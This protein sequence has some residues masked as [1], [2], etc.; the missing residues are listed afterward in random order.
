MHSYMGQLLHVDLTKRDWRAIPVDDRLAALFVGGKGFGAKILYDLLPPGCD[1]LSPENVLMFM[2]GPLTGTLAPAMRGCVVTRSPL[3]GTFVDS[4]FG[5][6]FAPEIRYA[7]FDGIVITGAA[8]RPCYIR[9]DDGAVEIRE[10]AHLWGLDTFT[11]TARIKEELGDR[12]VKI[13]CIGPAGEKKVSYALVNCEYNRHAGRGGTGA[14][15]GSKNLKALVLRGN[16]IVRPCDA[17]A[18]TAAVE[19]AYRELRAD[20]SITA[21]TVDGTAGSIDFANDEYLL[22]AYNYY[23]GA[24]DGTA[25]LNATA[26]REQ[27]WLRNVACAGCPIACGKVGRIRRGRHKGLVSDVVEYETAAL[28]GSNLGLSDAVSYTHLTLPTKRIV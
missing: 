28:M 11:V 24:F 3:T 23:D 16:R 27:L 5:G 1:P 4:Y 12:T 15:M 7:G 2:T 18:F 22:P 13:A 19:Q 21:F 17:A 9:V 26:Q 6:H 8:D 10:A 14:V 25:G 20:E